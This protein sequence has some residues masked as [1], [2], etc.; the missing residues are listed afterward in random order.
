MRGLPRCPAEIGERRPDQ[1]L[2]VRLRAAFERGIPA[3]RLGTVAIIAQGVSSL[4]TLAVGLV[5]ARELGAAALGQFGLL[6]VVL[7][8]FVAIQGAWVGDALAVLPSDETSRAG[9][10]TTQWLHVLAAL[11]FGPLV[12]FVGANGGL[13]VALL[14]GAA[15]AAWELREY[16]RR[17]L[18]A[19][20]A[21][22]RQIVSDMSYL[23]LSI[24]VL[25]LLLLLDALTP[26]TVWLSMLIGGSGSA[27]VA[28]LLLPQGQRLQLPRRTMTGVAAVT[29]FGCWRGAHAATGYVAQ[30]GVRY[31]VVLAGSLAVLGAIEAARIVVAPV[32]ILLASVMNVLLPVF[33]RRKAAVRARALHACAAVLSLACLLYGVVVVAMADQLTEL[34]YGGSVVP[35]LSALISWVLVATSVAISTPYTVSVLVNEGSKVVFNAKALGSLLGIGVAA[36]I[37]LV[38]APVMAPLGL[39][40]GNIVSAGM[41]IRA[42]CRALEP[43]GGE[44]VGASGCLLRAK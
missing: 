8:L 15:T 39:A 4:S 7:T 31:A 9:I 2:T 20:L 27:L 34:L 33:A 37:C 18:M 23:V 32:L 41:L 35:P 3:V 43:D 1:A 36:A 24:G 10:A 12:V 19:R 5:V 38:G 28:Q 11:V 14:F 21:F 16:G 30:V 40:A 22:G 17:A 26:A 6:F 42:S 29:R 25:I 44:G 13:W